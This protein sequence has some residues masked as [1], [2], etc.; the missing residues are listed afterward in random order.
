MAAVL[1]L[2]MTVILW[3]LWRREGQRQSGRPG[4]AL[5]IPALVLCL[6]AL[7]YALQGY[8][9]ETGPWLEQQQAYKDVARQIIAG[10]T[11][12]QVA[13]K[14]PA[15]QLA[16]VLQSELARHPSAVGWYALGM[17]YD[18]L[19]A[20]QLA[21]EAARK[22]LVLAD[23]KA[24]IHLL[25]ARALIEQNQG[26]LTEDAQAQIDQVLASQPN[27]DGA[28]MMLAMAADRAGRYPL[29]IHA[30]SSLLKRHDQ[31]ETG[32]LLRMGLEK[33]RQ[34]LARQDRFAS[35]PATIRATDLP[36]G[37]TLFVYL[38]RAGSQG[39]PL[40]AHRTV[41]RDFPATVTLTPG[42]WLQP[43]P[44]EGAALVIGARYT[45]APGASVDQAGISADPV[46]L[47][48]PLEGPVSLQLK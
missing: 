27:H 23:D 48:M 14:V 43:F 28:W 10:Q 11:P 1:L 4:L 21:E 42:D 47:T 16:R 15:G 17:I 37:G 35:L 6:A 22:A 33:S 29:A 2:V 31:G 32:K 20:P 39:Q 9:R 26:R 24:D 44:E 8:N 5:A 34:Q 13:A 12:D 40:A 41:V 25:L 18:Q 38:R 30:W 19:G 3:G 46:P 36:A 7:G 45:P